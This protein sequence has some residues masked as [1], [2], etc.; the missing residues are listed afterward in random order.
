MTSGQDIG[1]LARSLFPGGRPGWIMG[2]TDEDSAARTQQVISEG[3][4]VVFEAAFLVDGLYVRVDVLERGDKGGWN[5]IEV[6][7]STSFK[8]EQAADVWFQMYVLG[9]AGVQL[10]SV[11]V[12]L[13]NAEYVLDGELDL[14]QFFRRQNVEK[15]FKKTAEGFQT[16][17]GE[18]YDVLTLDSEP[19]ALCLP[20]CKDCLFK[21]YCWPELD[22]NDV[23][24]L[25]SLRPDKVRKFR[26]DGIQFIRDLPDEVELTTHQA[27][28]R[29]VIRFD[30]PYIS[31][32][33][34]DALD[35]VKFPAA[36]VDFETYMPGIPKIQGTR[37]FQILPV[38]WSCHIVE[39]DG[40]ERHFEFLHDSQEDPRALFAESLWNALQGAESIIHY[41]PFEITQI[42]SLKEQGI[43][44]GDELF[45]IFDAKKVDLEKIIKEHVMLRAFEGK[46]S[47]KKTLPALVPNMGYSGLAVQN[48]D[49][50]V[51]EFERM[52][53]GELTPIARA[54]SRANLLEYCKL[55]TKAMVEIYAALRRL[56]P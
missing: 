49:A 33:L 52:I 2:D 22:S 35:A 12:M 28:M 24:Y 7:S 44:F 32:G 37:P 5:L 50:A 30:R 48:G 53:Y 54:E 11:E 6:K 36:F 27:R 55:D 40:T 31:E 29:D 4:D 13:C 17:V 8:K 47:I 14:S 18:L 41:S 26:E 10:D 15:E 38:Q 39:A 20:Y 45:E 51:A 19:D 42:R 21:N 1:R 23:M 34:N 3:A 16:K 9:L 56:K 43:R 25:P 46:T